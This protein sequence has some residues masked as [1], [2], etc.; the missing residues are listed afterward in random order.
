ME[1][2]QACSRHFKFQQPHSEEETVILRKLIGRPDPSVRRIRP[3][4][5]LSA[6]FACLPVRPRAWDLGPGSMSPWAKE[7]VRVNTDKTILARQST[8]VF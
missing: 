7:N 6:A 8:Q 5:R 4:L 1:E 3:S 2:E